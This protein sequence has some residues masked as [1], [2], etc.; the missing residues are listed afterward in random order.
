MAS[1]G[2]EADTT[3]G[4]ALASLQ[5]LE[6]DTDHVHILASS[7]NQRFTDNGAIEDTVEIYWSL[8]G[9]PGI[10]TTRV[11]RD[12]DW[13]A[14]AYFYVGLEAALVQ[15]IYDGWPDK[16]TPPPGV[17]LPPPTEPP[18]LIPEPGVAVPL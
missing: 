14:Q 11:P 1:T 13:L 2:F 16:N 7:L 10:F 17:T 3:I 8:Y 6:D 15:R 5:L 4:A 9:R 18:T 12:I